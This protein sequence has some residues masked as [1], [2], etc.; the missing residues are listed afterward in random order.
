LQAEPWAAD[1]GL[2]EAIRRSL[3]VDGWWDFPAGLR[4][5]EAAALDEARG[6]HHDA[7]QVIVATEL[8]FRRQWAAIRRAAQLR[9]IALV[10]DLPIF[11]AG[12]GCDTWCSRELFRWGADGYPD[13]VSGA[14]PDDFSPT[15]QRWG[16]PLYHWP[17]H[18]ETGFAWW[19]ARFQASLALVDTVRVDH[20]RGFAAAWEIPAHA[21]DARQGR[22]VES[23]GHALFAALKA[24]QGGLPIIAEDLGVITPDVEQLREAVGA[25]GMKVLQFAFGGN[26]SHAYLPHNYPHPHWVAYTGTH[27]ND[28]A[29]GWYHSTTER[30]RHRYRV[31]TG[32]D[33]REPGW[34]LVRMAWSSTAQWAI[35]P[36][37]DVLNLG[38]EA[39]M[40]TPG[41][42]K[43]NW[44]WRTHDL[45]LHAAHRLAELAWVYG[46]KPADD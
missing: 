19:I 5:R 36:L 34:D 24:A 14:P 21:E 23:P 38:G 31:Y 25:P 39:R 8:I 46:R 3:G 2:F 12:D 6:L 40:N 41:V 13:P 1:W 26:A 20:F 45:P 42:A 44:G 30:A 22:W 4:D 15:G 29:V 10:G 37:Q 32:R 17:R 27:D 28:T 18:I 16:N 11:T 7:I 43:G 9:G 35:A 33:G